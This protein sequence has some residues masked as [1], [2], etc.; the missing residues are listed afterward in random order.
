M[1]PDEIL[2]H[3][4]MVGA[5]IVALISLA[6]EVASAAVA[7]SDPSWEGLTLKAG[8]ALALVYMVRQNA[9]ERDE[10]RKALAEQRAE[11][12]GVI[13]ANTAAKQEYITAMQDMKGSIDSQTGYFKTVAQTLINREVKPK[14]PAEPERQG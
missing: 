6:A 8:L 4:K 5:S 9:I 3:P 7:T 2:Q 1:I 13:S 11:I 14:L 10:H 12:L